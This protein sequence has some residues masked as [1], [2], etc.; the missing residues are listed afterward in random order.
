MPTTLP[1]LSTTL[2]S[3]LNSLSN[4]VRQKLSEH[5]TIYKIVIVASHI[6]RMMGMFAM[7]TLHPGSFLKKCS[8]ILIPSLLYRLSVEAPCPFKFA[9][10]SS[11]G[12]IA[13]HMFTLNTLSPFL[14][15]VPFWCY[16]TYVVILADTEVNKALQSKV[17]CRR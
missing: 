17:C 1:V 15:L 14:R 13:L 5:P 10:P 2:S 4:K 9:L 6:F 12:A 3:S 11:I 7:L 8:F 16:F